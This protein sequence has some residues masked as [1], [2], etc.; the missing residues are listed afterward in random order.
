MS[1]RVSL[2]EVERELDRVVDRLMSMPLAKA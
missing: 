2:H 1:E